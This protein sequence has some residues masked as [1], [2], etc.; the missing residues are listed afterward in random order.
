[1]GSNEEQVAKAMGGIVE[2]VSPQSIEE[3]YAHLIALGTIYKLPSRTVHTCW[4][5]EDPSPMGRFYQDR[6][7]LDNICYA[8]PVAHLHTYPFPAARL[9]RD[10]ITFYSYQHKQAALQNARLRLLRR[11][12]GK[13]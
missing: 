9:T 13:L 6:S 3:I 11:I 5:V 1:L 8:L 7:P 2:V 4:V 10:N 12:K